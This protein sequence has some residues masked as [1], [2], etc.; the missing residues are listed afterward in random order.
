MGDIWIRD[1]EIT[2]LIAISAVLIVMP[3]QLLLCFKAKRIFFR[4][5]PSVILAAAA[6]VFFC[7]M[8]AATDWDAIGYA[9]LGVFAGVLLLAS[10]LAWG[11]WALLRNIRK[12]KNRE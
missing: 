4:L 9:I 6:A 7:M 5:L 10:G 2:T 11:L 1:M 3:V 8:R 12:K